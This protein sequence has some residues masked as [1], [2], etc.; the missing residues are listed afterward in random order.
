MKTK[1][2]ILTIL[3]LSLLVITNAQPIPPTSPSGSPVP[4]GG[5]FGLLLLMLSGIGLS[6]KQYL[7]KN[8]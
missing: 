1:I 3:F 4:I 7:K 5:V 2:I 8:K 6:L